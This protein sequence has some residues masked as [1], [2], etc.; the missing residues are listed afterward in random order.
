[1]LPANVERRVA[2]E[3]AT[4]ETW[5]RYV[6]PKGA[7]VAMRSFG[8]SAPAKDLFKHFG[9]TVENVLKVVQSIL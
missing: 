3:A 8:A 9:F 4:P 5:W 1:V 2:I 6:G 7:V